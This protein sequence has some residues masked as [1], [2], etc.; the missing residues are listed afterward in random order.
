[1]P[2]SKTDLLT[3]H[4]TQTV[5]PACA[6]CPRDFGLFPDALQGAF[7]D[8]AGKAVLLRKSEYFGTFHGPSC[9]LELFLHTD[10]NWA[11]FLAKFNPSQIV[12]VGNVVLTQ[13]GMN[14]NV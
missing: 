1:M 4:C 13:D 8:A 9:R 6:T 5:F 14:P 12:D 2:V 3:F 7:K 10:I 11:D